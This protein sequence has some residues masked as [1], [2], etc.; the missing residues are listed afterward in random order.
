VLEETIKDFSDFIRHTEVF[1]LIWEVNI[2]RGQ[3]VRGNLVPSVARTN[4]RVDTTEK[5]KRQLIQLRLMGSSLLPDQAAKD[6]D[7]LVLAQHFG[8]KT[9]LLDWTSNPLAALWF[10]CADDLPGD[11]YVYALGADNLLA[12]DVY[13]KDPFKSSDA[14]VFQPH[15]NN[16]R[17]I[18]QHGWFTL[19]RYL[20]KSRKFVA[21]ETKS[22]LKDR[23]TEIRIPAESRSDILHSLDRHGI[24]SRTL[25]PDLQG[26]CQHL[27]WKYPAAQPIIPPDAAR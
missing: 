16:A 27:N 20:A 26:L 5:E 3:A 22:E 2:F 6:L 19:H 11:A 7:L 9:R 13:T 24:S 25:F 23:L 10:A 4:P 8:L 12:E 17:I 21:L 18:A 15:L 14:T 1:D